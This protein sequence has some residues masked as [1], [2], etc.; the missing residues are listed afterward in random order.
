MYNVRVNHIAEDV[1]AAIQA[2]LIDFVSKYDFPHVTAITD[3]AWLREAFTEYFRNRHTYEW[4]KAQAYAKARAEGRDLRGVAA[5][6]MC[7]PNRI[8]TGALGNY[9][10]K[11]GQTKC[12]TIHTYGIDPM[13]P[14]CRMNL[15]GKILDIKT[16][17]VHSFPAA[18]DDLKRTDI[19]MIP[20]HVNCRHVMAP[21]DDFGI[22]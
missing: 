22:E 14:S 17:L 16:V 7:E 15:E 9:L 12:R 21:L 1:P 6:S 19:P 11:K 8:H 20:Q 13:Q 18:Y 3:K 4:L 2:E 10:L 5:V